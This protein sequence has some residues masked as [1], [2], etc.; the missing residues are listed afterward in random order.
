MKKCECKPGKC[1]LMAIYPNTNANL[2]CDEDCYLTYSENNEHY[3]Q[4]W[5]ELWVESVKEE[6]ND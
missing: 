2:A 6:E 4:E 5:P 1:L 3:K